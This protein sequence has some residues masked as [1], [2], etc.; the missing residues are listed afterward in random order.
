MM[1][2][3]HLRVLSVMAKHFP[4]DTQRLFNAGCRASQIA[5]ARSHFLDKAAL[6]QAESGAILYSSSIG[7]L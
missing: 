1:T 6:H 7:A 4:A 5:S 2:V 3:I